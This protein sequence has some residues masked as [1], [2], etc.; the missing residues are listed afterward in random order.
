ARGRPGP[1]GRH[2]APHRGV[3][4]RAAPPGGVRGRHR[5]RVDPGPRVHRRAPRDPRRDRVGRGPR[6][7]RPHGG[8]VSVA[9]WTTLPGSFPWPPR[10]L[11]VFSAFRVGYVDLRWDD[12]S[13]IMVGGGS[14][15]PT[16][17]GGTVTVTG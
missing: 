17:A 1:H 9:G 13:T 2:P 4:G 12:P 8:P 11:Q 15:V 3:G 14:I 7:V 5:G 16:R 10:N 6:R